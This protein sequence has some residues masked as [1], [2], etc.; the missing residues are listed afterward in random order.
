MLTKEAFN[1]LLKTLEEPPKH[2]IFIMATTD[3]Y[4][5]P[6]TI[7]SRSQIFRFELASPDVMFNY[8]KEIAKKE[9]IK[10]SDDALSIIVRRGGG[11]FRDSLSL[12]DQISTLS[13]TDIT[14]EMVLSAMG[15]TGDEKIVSLLTTYVSHD[16]TKT[17]TT[18]KELLAS[19]VKAEVLAENIINYIIENPQPEYLK[20]LPRLAD[21]KTPYA[22]AR[23]L[24][25]LTADM[26]QTTN[27]SP[28]P[29]PVVA[30][31]I[32]PTP[33]P[34]PAPAANFNWDDLVK[35]IGQ[36]NEAIYLHLKRATYKFDG[37]MLDIYPA[38][39]MGDTILQ[40]KN[41]L[42]ALRNETSVKITVHN[43][44]EKPDG[45]EN[46]AV[47]SKLSDIMGGEVK[48]DGG[49]NPF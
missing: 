23:L 13:D 8:L 35:R 24:V 33:T 29:A 12:L 36:K 16:I 1:A 37:T 47:L 11:S 17:T 28:A 38:N 15:I 42:K 20:L 10:I 19:G 31:P 39:K 21:V 43:L 22:E 49:E 30:Q 6:A 48:N 27:P 18:Y 3:A 25:A 26:L 45:A 5:V 41:N 44:D 46:D 32:A 34:A 7:A 40:S 9:D 14:S 4:K 2:V